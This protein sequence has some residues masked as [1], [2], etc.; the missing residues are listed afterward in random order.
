MASDSKT[1]VIQC[2]IA[3]GLSQ[4]EFG[5]L[6]GRSERTIQRWEDRGVTLIAS[7]GEALARALRA[8]RP[9][10]AAEV[11]ARTGTTL[12]RLGRAG[13]AAARGPTPATDSIDAVVRAAAHALGVA[14]EAIR[15]ALAAAFAKARETGL[16]VHAVAEALSRRR[17]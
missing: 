13:V 9:D 8:S 5:N 7:E 15:P 4:R 14:P 11:A 17:G 16:D 6:V 3:L 10:L 1:L 2:R 12:E